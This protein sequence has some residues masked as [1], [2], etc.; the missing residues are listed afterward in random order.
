MTRPCLLSIPSTSQAE[1]ATQS[2]LFCTR[3]LIISVVGGCVQD[4]Q[5]CAL[6]LGWL[7]GWRAAPWCSSSQW[8]AGRLG[9][10]NVLPLP[11]RVSRPGQA[12]VTLHCFAPLSRSDFAWLM[13]CD[14]TQLQGCL[15]C[16]SPH[17]PVRRGVKPCCSVTDGSQASY[18]LHSWHF[19]EHLNHSLQ[20]KVKSKRV[21]E[22]AVYSSV[23]PG[24]DTNHVSDIQRQD[25]A[26]TP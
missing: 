6:V 22:P 23:H 20:V 3:I 25:W 9:F 18:Q 8:Q 2:M 4:C 12:E 15:S 5:F 26:D 21:W 24:E 1:T 17:R 14:E 10:V 7:S 11:C 16:I 19:T 13:N